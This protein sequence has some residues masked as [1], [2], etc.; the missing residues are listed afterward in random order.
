MGQVYCKKLDQNGPVLY[1]FMPEARWLRDATFNRIELASGLCGN[2]S[3]YD[4]LRVRFKCHAPI[5]AEWWIESLGA[6]SR[7]TVEQVKLY[8]HYH[9]SDIEWVYVE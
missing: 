7:A 3:E 5:A 1:G 4:S 6:E 9:C 2:P 8:V